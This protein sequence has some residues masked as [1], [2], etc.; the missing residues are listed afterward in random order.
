MLDMAAPRA[1]AAGTNA[2][3]EGGGRG[4][5]DGSDD[6]AVPLPDAE[7]DIHPAHDRTVV[8]ERRVA[9]GLIAGEALILRTRGIR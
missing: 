3:D 9:M 8:D 7:Q 5:L 2:R 6:V 1:E 4:K